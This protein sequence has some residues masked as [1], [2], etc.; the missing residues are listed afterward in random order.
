MKMQPT[1][2]DVKAYF[3]VL[4]QNGMPLVDDI[5]TIPTQV[6]EGLT[7]EQQQFLLDKNGTKTSQ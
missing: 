2:S 1:Q 7:E 4:D 3:M 5:T 6:W